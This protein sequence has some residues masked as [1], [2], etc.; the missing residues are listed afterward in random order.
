MAFVSASLTGAS[1]VSGHTTPSAVEYNL[2]RLKGASIVDKVRVLDYAMT[3]SELNI[4]SISDVYT[5]DD[6]T[7]L[8]AEFTNNTEAGSIN[9]PSAIEMWDVVR[10]CCGSNIPVVIAVDLDGSE[11]SLVDYTA[12]K[13]NDYYYVVYPITATAVMA[14]IQSNTVTLCYDYYVFIDTVTGESFKFSLNIENMGKQFTSSVTTYEGFTQY[15]A[16]SQ[17]LLKYNT[18]SFTSLLGEV[19]GSVYSG[20]TVDTYRALEDF[21]TN[22]NEKIMKDRKGNIYRVFTENL[23]S[24][25]DEKPVEMPTMITF[26][27][28]EVGAV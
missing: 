10:Y 21:I 9:T 17:G 25:I 8:Y 28:T 4:L 12:I 26:T 16:K 18:S 11:S 27:W 2:I 1:L 22:G 15:P 19:V 7:L 3:T 13:P 14:Y 23:T 5:W 6:H 20:D 24:N